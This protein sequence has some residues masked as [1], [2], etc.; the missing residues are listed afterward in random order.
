MTEQLIRG[1]AHQWETVRS[2]TSRMQGKKLSP[3]PCFDIH[4]NPRSNGHDTDGDDIPYALVVT[5]DAPTES[6]L[7]EKIFKRYQFQLSELKP[8]IAIPVRVR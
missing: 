3:N 8:R 5:V 2:E 7:F 1:D 4:Y 6:A